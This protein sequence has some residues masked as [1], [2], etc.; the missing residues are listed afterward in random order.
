VDMSKAE[1]AKKLGQNMKKWRMKK[2]MSQGDISRA[3]AVDRSYV[4]NI[5]SGRMNP[6]LSTLEKLAKAIGISVKDLVE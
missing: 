3:L 6:T 5:E 1:S 4:S 2:K